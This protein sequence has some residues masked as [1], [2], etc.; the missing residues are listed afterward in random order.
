MRFEA[1][2]WLLPAGIAAAV[3]A[4]AARALAAVVAVVVVQVE[5]FYPES[6]PSGAAF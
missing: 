2:W 6:S 4:V 5:D 1:N 3:A